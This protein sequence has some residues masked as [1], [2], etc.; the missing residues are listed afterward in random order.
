MT[1]QDAIIELGHR[2]GLGYTAAEYALRGHPRGTD[3]RQ[4]VEDEVSSFEQGLEHMPNLK[5]E[6]GR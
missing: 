1:K 5:A 3:W 6:L 4:V 2:T